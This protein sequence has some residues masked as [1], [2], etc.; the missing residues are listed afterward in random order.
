[1]INTN[2]L[3]IIL[4]LCI[5]YL[6]YYISHQ[7]ITTSAYTK[8]NTNNRD[9]LVKNFDD[10]SSASDLLGTIYNR[11]FVMRDYLLQKLD[12]YPEFKPYN[13]Q[14]C[15]GITNL[16]LTE[17]APNGTHT[18]YTINKGKEISLCIR[19][20]KNAELHDINLIMYVVLHE[21]SHV[22]CPEKNHTD[23]FKKIFSFYL[24][25]ATKI[26]IYEPTNYQKNPTEYC[27]IV[28]D[29]NL[30]YKNTA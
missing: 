13:M 4:F 6:I 11:I 18:S 17:N 16:K 2:I 10:K 24:Q 20:A 26:G 29:E 1:M 14:F 19:S 7:S 8:S 9:Y 3:L 25:I 15:N 21:L 28:L 22:A 12:K 30:Y 27:G 23:L 5:L